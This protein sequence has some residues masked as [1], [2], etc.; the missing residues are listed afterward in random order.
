MTYHKDT[1]DNREKWEADI[2]EKIG[3]TIQPSLQGDLIPVA[4]QGYWKKIMEDACVNDLPVV[5]YFEVLRILYRG[6][7]TPEL[8]KI[9]QE[10][11]LEVYGLIVD[12]A[13]FPEIAR[14]YEIRET[15]TTVVVYKD[16]ILARRV[17]P[18]P[19]KD[20]HSLIQCVIKK[21]KYYPPRLVNY[22]EIFKPGVHRYSAQKNQGD[23]S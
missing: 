14:Y 6:S 11:A 3:I 21:I 13:A 19:E 2:I 17:G 4:N 7:I 5:I 9:R 8:P 20:F 12:I 16:K 18:L 22:G 10:I 15:P 23:R 1:V